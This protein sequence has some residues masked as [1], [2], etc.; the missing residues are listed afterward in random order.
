MSAAICNPMEQIFYLGEQELR[1]A[2][3]SPHSASPQGASL[4]LEAVSERSQQ[5]S[6]LIVYNDNIHL[7]G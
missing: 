6:M 2:Q 3:A 7:E 5:L 1:K 4:K